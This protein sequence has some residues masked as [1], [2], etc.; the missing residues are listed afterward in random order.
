MLIFNQSTYLYFRAKAPFKGFII[1][2]A[3]ANAFLQEKPGLLYTVANGALALKN[4]TACLLKY[5]TY[6]ST[7][8]MH[9]IYTELNYN[10]THY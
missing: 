9:R 8:N 7:K 5:Y 10:L 6:F 2:L 3:F 4:I 1:T